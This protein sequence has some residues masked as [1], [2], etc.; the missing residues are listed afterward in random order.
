M[1][2]ALL[3]LASASPRRKAL[4]DQ[5]GVRPSEIV[6]AN[7]DETPLKS[8]LPKSYV[9]RLARSKAKVPASD[10]PGAYILAADT[11]VACGRRILGKAENADDV[12]S[13]LKLLSGRAHRVYSGVALLAPDGTI[14]V[15]TAET[16][17]KV[18][19]LD[20]AAVAEYAL[21]KEGEGKAGGYAIQGLFAKH[22]IGIVGSYTNVVGLPLYETANLLKGRG[23]LP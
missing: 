4:L 12:R 10:H 2:D 16:R 9:E 6:S 1:S 7:I 5:I 8:E 21:S 23:L 18:R 19:V 22:V 3:I 13:Y 14:S 20:N 17:V 11:T 15:R